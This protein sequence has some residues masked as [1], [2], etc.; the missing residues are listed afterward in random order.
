MIS[1]KEL[2]KTDLS[3][4][5]FDYN[6]LIH[7]CAQQILSAKNDYYTSIKDDQIRTEEIEKD[8]ITNCINYTNL[9]ISSLVAKQTYF[10]IDGVAPR[11][12][13][14]QQRERRYKSHHFKA[15]ENKDKSALWDSNKIT[16]GTEFMSELSE[17]IE[18]FIST[19]EKSFPDRKF[20][21]SDASEPGEG[22]HK[23]MKILNSK[24]IS[25]V[26]GKFLIYA[27]DAD[28]IFLSLINRRVN[29]IILVRDNS[30]NCNL[31]MNNQ[32]MTF[33]NINNLKQYIYLDMM[34]KFKSKNVTYNAGPDRFI[35]D[36]IVLC[37]FL[38]NDFLD[39]LYCL[40]IKENGLDVICTSYI[41]AWKGESLVRDQNTQIRD[42][43]NLV[44]LRDIFYHLKFYEEHYISQNRSRPSKID[45]RIIDEVNS[46]VNSKV[47]FYNYN[48]KNTEGDVKKKVYSFYDIQNV[49]TACM[50]YLEGLYWIS[51]Y[52][53]NSL[54]N[55]LHDNW[56]WYYAHDTVPFCIDMFNFL[57]NNIDTLREF[58]STTPNLTTSKPLTAIKQLCLVLPKESLTSISKGKFNNECT[59][60]VKSG[61]FQDKICVDIS[62]KEYL[63]Q[64]KVF[65]KKDNKNIINY[66]FE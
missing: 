61:F 20:I 27:L 3:G 46:D 58:L 14:N 9:I 50:H 44:L 7:P 47:Y 32:V 30:F 45:Q 10:V 56:S 57:K 5:F 28:L 21:L 8:I 18:K 55:H 15:F 17:K 4:L 26:A 23:I 62:N 53:G 6:S 52:Y 11:S 43:I 35:S 37:F 34:N 42:S 13:M 40:S 64:S 16:P 38:G 33:L 22:E 60:L 1:L 49:N 63:W 59:L 29:D 41:K 51:G 12:K 19:L 48:F 65:F 25:F 54:S 39:H 24:D 36:Y 2:Q 31:D 66:L